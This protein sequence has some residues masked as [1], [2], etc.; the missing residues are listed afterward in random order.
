M[1]GKNKVNIAIGIFIIIMIIMVYSC[2]K[3]NG[4]KIKISP[5][6]EQSNTQLAPDFSENDL[7][8]KNTISLSQ[9][10]GKIVL[11]NF[12]ATWCPPCKA[13]IPDFI[14]L[15]SDNK[16]KLII[17]GA[18]VDE[19]KSLVIPFFKSMKMNYPVIYATSD[20]I[21]AYGGITAIPTSFLINQ[22]GEIVK[23]FVGY[24]DK[25][26]WSSEIKNLLTNL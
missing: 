14:R 26:E 23:K 13:E 1:I 11:L 4:S 16:D 12:W 10:R 5:K 3:F 17:I 8:G 25:S 22:K 20:M 18:S 21:S 24:R 15:Y 9:L 2:N 6:D 7:S 19:N